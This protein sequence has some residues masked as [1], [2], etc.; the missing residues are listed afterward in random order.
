MEIGLD[1]KSN[2]SERLNLKFDSYHHEKN[3]KSGFI[4][5]RY[6][7]TIGSWYTFFMTF[8]NPKV[9]SEISIK[10]GKERGNHYLNSFRVSGVGLSYN[11][12][13]YIRNSGSI[14]TDINFSRNKEYS[15]LTT[16]PPEALNGQTLGNNISANILLN[17]FIKKDVSLSMSVNYIDNTRYEKMI[18]F[19]G[20]FRAYL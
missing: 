11:G 6:R 9:E 2:I 19:M 7:N 20:E 16:I 12:R 10:Y 18:T 5:E 13:I 8:N 15:G 1:G 14:M 3:V 17:Y 4:S